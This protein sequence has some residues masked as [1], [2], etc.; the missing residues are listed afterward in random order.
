MVL[1]DWWCPAKG[2]ALRLWRGREM[3]RESEEGCSKVR[4]VAFFG[5]E[6]LKNP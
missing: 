6:N 1:V 3:W 4:L 2:W 5:V